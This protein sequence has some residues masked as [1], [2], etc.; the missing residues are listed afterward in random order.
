MLSDLRESG[1]IEQD[2]DMVAFLYRDDYYDPESEKKNMVE[3]I[4]AKHRNGPVG[5]VDLYFMKDIQKMVG[6]EHK[7][8]A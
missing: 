8:G 7:R 2:A 6:M 5:S 3:V 1:A 4:V